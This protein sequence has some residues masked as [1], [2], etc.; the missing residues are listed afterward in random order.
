MCSS[1]FPTD[2]PSRLPST[3][4]S[5]S[6]TGLPSVSPT[7]FPSKMP[8]E[9]PTNEPTVSDYPSRTPSVSPTG[10]PSIS[11]TPAPTTRTSV[12][13]SRP[14]LS[15]C[16]TTGNSDSTNDENGLIV[17]YYYGIILKGDGSSVT[18]ALPLLEKSMSSDLLDT[19]L[20]CENGDRRLQLR[21]SHRA[22]RAT[23]LDS[24]PT[25]EVNEKG[26]CYPMF[27]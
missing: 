24:L 20:E 4:P 7:D 5:V 10:E 12:D 13:P 9:S 1:V 8:S 11:P 14:T 21:S 17:G 15:Y 26:K 3:S 23:A 18:E 2:Q 25:D 19:L 6:P 22:L 27:Q 16:S